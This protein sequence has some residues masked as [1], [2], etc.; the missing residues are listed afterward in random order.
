MREE[1][2]T[3]YT[4]RINQF[5]LFEKFSKERCR[6]QSFGAGGYRWRLILYPNGNDKGKGSHLSLYLKIEDT[7][8]LPLGWEVQVVFRF[9]AFDQIRGQYLMFEETQ[10]KRFH[11]MKTEWGSDE[12][13]PLRVFKNQSYG[14]LVN[15]TSMLGAEIFIFGESRTGQSS[16]DCLVKDTM[17]VRAVFS[18]AL[19]GPKCMIFVF[20][21]GKASSVC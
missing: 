19:A 8:S 15:D 21:S 4:F 11:A 18:P 7:T 16:S 6:S 14:Y 20:S 12:F 2:P 10:G 17:K 9:F 3:H 1:P 13:I 5:S